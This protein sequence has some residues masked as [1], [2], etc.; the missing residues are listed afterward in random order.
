MVDTDVKC[1]RFVCLLVVCF[2][3][4]LL[5]LLLLLLL[6]FFTDTATVVDVIFNVTTIFNVWVCLEFLIYDL[7]N[8][9][10]FRK[11]SACGF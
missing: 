4:F 10:S 3:L 1:G 6:F 2:C 8:L 5:L 7:N 9:I 11:E